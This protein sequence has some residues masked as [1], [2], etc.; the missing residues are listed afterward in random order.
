MLRP[1]PLAHPPPGP[2]HQTPPHTLLPQPISRPPTRSETVSLRRTDLHVAAVRRGV[3]VGA[4]CAAGAE[5]SGEGGGG[6]GRGRWGWGGR[7]GAVVC[8]GA[9]DGEGVEG[10][11]G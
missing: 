4:E 3:R 2:L 8:C 9:G 5:G 7:Y 1:R 11:A 6:V 10:G